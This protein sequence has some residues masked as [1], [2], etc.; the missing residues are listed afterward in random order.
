MMNRENPPKWVPILWFG[1]S[2]IWAL[3]LCV[4]FIRQ[5]TEPTFILMHALCLACSLFSAIRS[6]GRYK[7][8]EDRQDDLY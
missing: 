5:N 8:S 2:A 6:Y 4:D 1:F 3:A 7:N